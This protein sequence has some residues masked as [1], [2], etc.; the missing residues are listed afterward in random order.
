MKIEDVIHQK[1]FPYPAQKV[2]INIMYSASWLGG[3]MKRALE[4]FDLSWQQ[5]NI[6]RIL[7]GQKGHPAS[8]KL[9]T[10]RMIDKTSNTSRL[11]DKL[12]NK[13]YVERLICPED[14][15]KVEISLT[16]DGIK[17]VQL[18]TKAMDRNMQALF[19]HMPEKDLDTL[20]NLLDLMR[21][22][23]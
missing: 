18:A 15:R 4:D 5:F 21:T 14:R 16:E 3:E 6:M 19:K 23:D 8:L 7:K 17:I 20:N 1:N 22:P 2:A 11:I 10:T 9:L 12:L 13:K